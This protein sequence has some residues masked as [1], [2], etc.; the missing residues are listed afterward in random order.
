MPDYIEEYLCQ[1]KDNPDINQRDTLYTPLDTKEP[2]LRSLRL[3][4][5]RGGGGELNVK[6]VVAQEKRLIISGASGMGKTTTLKW[7]TLVYAENYLGGAE[8]LIPLYVDLGRFKRGLFYDH[9][10]I[11]AQENGLGG[12]DFS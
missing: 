4:D 8:R 11:N 7:L 10:L 9:A 1:I 6:D 2:L 5:E 3:Q 12:G